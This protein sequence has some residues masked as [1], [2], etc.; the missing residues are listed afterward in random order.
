MFRRYPNEGLK[1]RKQGHLAIGGA[2]I[3]RNR[4]IINNTNL[5][6]DMA[7]FRT[8]QLSKAPYILIHTMG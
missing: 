4:V 8:I 7:Q 5:L 6:P 1:A 3:C 2:F